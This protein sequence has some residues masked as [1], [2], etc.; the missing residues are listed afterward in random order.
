MDPDKNLDRW[1]RRQ[2]MA[3][4]MRDLR[5]LASPKAWPVLFAA[6]IAV[7]LLVFIAGFNTAPGRLIETVDG[8]IISEFRAASKYSSGWTSATVQLTDGTRVTAR[9]PS[10]SIEPVGAMVRL[11]HYERTWGPI[12]SHW[13]AVARADAG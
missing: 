5:A 6:V 2:R 10:T 3:A 13:Y 11:R 7:P 12:R 4:V 1:L 8:R 9:M